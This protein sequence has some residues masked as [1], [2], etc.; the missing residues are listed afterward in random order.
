MAPKCGYIGW[1]VIRQLLDLMESL[2]QSS[3]LAI[4]WPPATHTYRVLAVA[5]GISLAIH[6]AFTEWPITLP[7]D[8]DDIPLTATLTELPPPP[9]P[10]PQPPRKATPRA[11]RVSANQSVSNAV[12]RGDAVAPEADAATTAVPPAALAREVAAPA[13]LTEAVDAP[14]PLPESAKS[15]P[16]RVDLA[17]KLYLG[18]HGF[19]IGDATYRFEHSGNRYRIYTV[20]KAKGL[21]AL[22][23]R[24][25]GRL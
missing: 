25:E 22:L 9:L 11:S 10:V 7:D 1:P 24:G 5:L 15:L 17:Y 21:A 12:S 3:S 14:P 6:L 13:P 20:G 4:R 23:V 16:P 2:A 8:P 19:L 18:S